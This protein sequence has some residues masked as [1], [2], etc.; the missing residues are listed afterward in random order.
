MQPLTMYVNNMECN[1]ASG[2]G[3]AAARLEEFAN[4]GV[5]A[6]KIMSMGSDGA[7]VMTGKHNG[8]THN[9][10]YVLT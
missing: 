5:P 8:I 4:R 2:K 1:D 3:I 9:K 7:S 10:N 6:Q